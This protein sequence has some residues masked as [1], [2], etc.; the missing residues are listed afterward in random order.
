[1]IILTPCWLNDDN[2]N[3]NHH[4]GMYVLSMQNINAHLSKNSM[5]PSE[6]VSQFICL[7]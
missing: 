2:S 4:L 6:P 7:H 1:M 5:A 3:P